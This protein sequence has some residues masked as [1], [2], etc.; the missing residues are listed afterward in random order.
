MSVIYT[1]RV[2]GKK[3]RREI[4][5]VYQGGKVLVGKPVDCNGCAFAGDTPEQRKDCAHAE[6]AA[7]SGR[8]PKSKV[9]EFHFKEIKDVR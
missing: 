2:T 4:C 9:V 1:S 6:C 8:W 7:V 3:Y 5:T